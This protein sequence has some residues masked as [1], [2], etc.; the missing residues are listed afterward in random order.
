MVIDMT[1]Y[2]E[3]TKLYDQI[4]TMPVWQVTDDTL[5]YFQNKLAD[6]L[7]ISMQNFDKH[8]RTLEDFNQKN[9]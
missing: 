7:S 3:T 6:L 2:N 5:V 1:I 4:R 8:Q 9:R